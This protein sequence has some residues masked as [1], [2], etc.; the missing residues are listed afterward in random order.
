MSE[1]PAPRANL[2]NE[3]LNSGAEGG[4]FG[5]SGKG[6]IAKAAGSRL[7]AAGFELVRI[8]PSFFIQMDDAKRTGI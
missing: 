4:G 8:N 5:S 3:Q 2:T 6:R 7:G 1:P